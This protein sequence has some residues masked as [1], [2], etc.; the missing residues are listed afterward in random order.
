MWPSGTRRAASRSDDVGREVAVQ[1]FDSLSEA[2][3]SRTGSACSVGLSLGRGTQVPIPRPG[4]RSGV[5]VANGG[6]AGLECAMVSGACRPSFV[7]ASRGG[8]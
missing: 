5:P 6:R 1:R 4:G 2:L 8:S 7:V 3:S